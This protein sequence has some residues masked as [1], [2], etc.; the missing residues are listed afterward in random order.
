[1]PQ[2]GP[3]G[4]TMGA[5]AHRLVPHLVGG[6]E[7]AI[8]LD[9]RPEARHPLGIA[10][11]EVR[12]RVRDRAREP[13]GVDLARPE[14]ALL[15]QLA[16]QVAPVDL[17]HRAD[18]LLALRPAHVED[19]GL[20]APLD[21]RGEGLDRLGGLIPVHGRV[22]RQRD[23][24]PERDPHVAAEGLA[25]L[26]RDAHR[27]QGERRSAPGRLVVQRDARGAG[28]DA[29][30]A[31]LR[32]GRALRVDPD[33]LP[34]LEGAEA[35]GEG[36]GVP[37][38]LVGIVLLAV[39][40]DRP[41]GGEEA[42]HQRIAEQGGGRQVVHLPGQDPADQQGVDQVVGVVDAEEH[43]A[44]GRHRCPRGPRPGP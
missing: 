7:G 17:V 40:R 26:E 5:T 37:V 34:P 4:R 44:R 15:L 13:Q 23:G 22:G 27:D 24:L 2:P 20:H 1:M 38:H 12:R 25:R 41:A 33:E 39:D 31:A 8:L 19:L 29:L 30:D 35:G 14:A 36:I 3:R 16:D 11:L 10:L 32:M 9:R 18:E 42:G 6:E 21:R 28:L 43:R